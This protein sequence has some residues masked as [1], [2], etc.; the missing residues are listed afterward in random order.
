MGEQGKVTLRVFVDTNGLPARVE[1]ATSS[2][3]PRLDNAAIETVRRWK[4]V[5][6]R[7]GDTPI[8][9]SVL[10]PLVFKLD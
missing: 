8:A 1:L 6:A 3:Y 9:G 10:V 2:G 5:A 7:Q 4:F